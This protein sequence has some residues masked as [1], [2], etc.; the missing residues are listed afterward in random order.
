ML[1]LLLGFSTA[2]L[3]WLILF[4]TSFKP[5]ANTSPITPITPS[6]PTHIP[7]A[8][9]YEWS[10]DFTQLAYQH[11]TPNAPTS[12]IKIWNPSNQTT[13]LI[14]HINSDEHWLSYGEVD[15]AWLNTSTLAYSEIITD[16]SLPNWQIIL[17]SHTSSTL[18]QNRGLIAFSPN[19]QAL[20]TVTS[21]GPTPSES[22]QYE[23]ILANNQVIQTKINANNTKCAWIEN[24][25]LKCYYTT[26][27]RKQINFNVTVSLP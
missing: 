10:P 22:L 23:I 17:G 16:D 19:H 24:S 12:A 5:V 1:Q 13:T 2:L 4:N 27:D 11:L 20:L 9:E 6:I 15:L 7:A 14:T 26:S 25:T 18:W 8:P 3:F 21:V